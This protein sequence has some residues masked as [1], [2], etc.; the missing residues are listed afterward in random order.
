ML[1]KS[2]HSYHIGLTR[3]QSGSDVLDNL[4]TLGAAAIANSIASGEHNGPESNR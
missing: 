4:T 3:G 2:M 1:L